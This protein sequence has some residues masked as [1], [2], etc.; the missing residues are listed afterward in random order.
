MKHALLVMAV[1]LSIMVTAQDTKYQTYTAELVVA[2]QKNDS[3]FNWKNKNI[4]VNLNYK[5]GNFSVKIYNTDFTN[6][7]QD[8]AFI[9]NTD[10]QPSEY[11]FTG[12]FPID[13]IINQKQTNQEY[14]VELELI[15]K[16]INLSEMVNFKM[17]IVK[18]NQGKGQY[19]IFTLSGT[20][21]NEKVKIPAFKNYDNNIAIRILF[22]AFWNS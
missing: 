19:R 20:L 16:D 17:T 3:A 9:E 4:I 22:N 14:D 7:Q 15:N 6:E 5:T 8:I 21:N 10:N 13:K 18:P 11:K 12:I 2:A 1:I